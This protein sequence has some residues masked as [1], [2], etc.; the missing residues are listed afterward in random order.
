MGLA[1]TWVKGQS[2]NPSGRNGPRPK[3]IEYKKFVQLCREHAHE[4]LSCLLEVMRTS[5]SASSRT[6][7]AIELLDRA[8]GKSKEHIQ[9]GTDKPVAELPPAERLR[10]LQQ[11]MEQVQQEIQ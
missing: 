10:V 9:L 11:A 6:R 5:T 4:A 2:G 8:F 7:A 3:T 1:L